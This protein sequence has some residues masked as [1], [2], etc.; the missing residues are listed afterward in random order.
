METNNKIIKE[1]TDG[2]NMGSAYWALRVWH[3]DLIP[4]HP[5]STSVPFLPCSAYSSTRKIKVARS[6]QTMATM[7]HI[8][9]QRQQCVTL[10][11]VTQE[12]STMVNTMRTSY[13]M[14]LCGHASTSSTNCITNM[15]TSYI[16]RVWPCFSI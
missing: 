10:C 11:G 8:M 2:L 16:M 6:T 15:R 13:F 1:N 5:Q 7:Y 12:D 9:W 3:G 4:G 14:G